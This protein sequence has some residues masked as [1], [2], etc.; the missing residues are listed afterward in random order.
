LISAAASFS[1]HSG[2]VLLHFVTARF[3][4]GTLYGFSFGLARF[5][6]LFLFENTFFDGFTDSYC[7]NGKLTVS[8]NTKPGTG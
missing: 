6:I 4:N 8:I 5:L 2:S 3:V 1:F 7:H